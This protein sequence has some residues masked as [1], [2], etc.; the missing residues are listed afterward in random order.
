MEISY[1]N[2]IVSLNTKF[3]EIN[4]VSAEHCTSWLIIGIRIRIEIAKNQ[5]KARKLEIPDY[6]GDNEFDIATIQ[7]F[8]Q[9][10]TV[11]IYNEYRSVVPT[12]RSIITV[13]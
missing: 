3:A 6:H 2:G 11:H 12:E 4:C 10:A 13:K 7:C 1:V 5:N 9:P 8:T